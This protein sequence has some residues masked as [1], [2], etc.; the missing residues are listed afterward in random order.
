M[1]ATSPQAWVVTGPTSGMGRRAAL[2]LA[3]GQQ[4]PG[5]VHAEHGPDPD[6]LIGEHPEGE[7]LEPATHRGLLPGPAH[8]RPRAAA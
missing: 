5:K 1:T 3:A 2:E 6:H 7:H 8:G 4:R